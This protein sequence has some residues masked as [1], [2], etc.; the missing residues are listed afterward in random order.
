MK[1]QV[2]RENS[3]KLR[4]N[5]EK[6]KKLIVEKGLSAAVCAKEVGLAEYTIRGFMEGKTCTPKT[7]KKFCDHYGLDIW[8]Y[9]R[10]VD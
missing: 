1:K 4:A 8:E 9:F 3:M 2:K 7:V 6:I 10:I 5:K